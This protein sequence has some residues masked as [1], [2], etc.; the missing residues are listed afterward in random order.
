MRNIVKFFLERKL[1]VNLIVI[2]VIISGLLALNKIPREGLPNVDIMQVLINTRY[3]GAS[4]EDVEL[5]VTIPIEDELKSIEGIQDLY[6]VSKENFSNFKIML[7]K[8]L[9]SEEAKEVKPI[10]YVH[11]PIEVEEIIK[12]LDSHFSK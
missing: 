12:L 6:S 5:N 2:L 3:P 1:M 10:A 8:N 4:P 11:K 9:S 7:N